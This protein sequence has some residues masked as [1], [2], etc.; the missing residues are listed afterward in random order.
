M[1]PCA[2]CREAL[3]DALAPLARLGPD[4]LAASEG[5]IYL[6]AKLPPGACQDMPEVISVCVTHLHVRAL[7]QEHGYPAGHVRALKQ[8]HG[9]PAGHVRALKQETWVPCRAC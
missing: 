7:K 1:A 6:W 9:Y 5:A 3:V 2:A 4:Y 8:E